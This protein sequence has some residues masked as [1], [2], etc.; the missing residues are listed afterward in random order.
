M[1]CLIRRTVY[2]LRI[3]TVIAWS[4]DDIFAS[5]YRNIWC[6]YSEKKKRDGSE[7]N[8]CLQTHDKRIILSSDICAY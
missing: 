8:L 4:D 2:A 3:G 6:M 7:F 5:L 1:P